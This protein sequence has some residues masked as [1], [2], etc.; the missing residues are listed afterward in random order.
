M[1]PN[2]PLDIVEYPS[3]EGGPAAYDV[4][5]VTALRK[6]MAFV[7]H[8]A[9]EPGYA[10]N[11]AHK[12]K[13]S[14]QYASRLPGARLVPLAVE[15]GGRWHPTVPALLRTWA[16]AYVARA[17]GLGGE[18]VG[19]VVARWAAR[20]SAA[21]LRGNAATLRRAGFAPTTPPVAEG[22]DDGPLAY[23]L[24]EGSSAYELLVT[25]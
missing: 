1:G 3:A 2:A 9:E 11:R 6:D 23:L 14:S 8:C 19:L 17:L 4:T 13:L 5:V 20:L 22:G 25:H 7:A 18:A 24:P 10:A 21:L 16:R 12:A 15:V